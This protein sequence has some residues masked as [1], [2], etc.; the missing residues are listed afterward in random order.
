MA[1]EFD[2]IEQDAKVEE[3][4]PDEAYQLDRKAVSAILYAVDIE[5]QAKLIE[6]MDPLHPADIAD[7]LEQINA[8]D[9]SR[10]I[11]LY[12]REFDGDILSELDE[13]IRDEVIAVLTPQVLTQAVR[14][15]DSDDVVDL[16]EDMDDSQQEAILD[17][18]EDAD[19]LAVKQA[20]SYPEFSAGRLMQREVVMAPEHWTVGDA[21][22]HLR[23]SSEED[24]P[25]QFY[26]IVVVDPRLHPVGNV[27]LGKV[28][29]SR[30]DVPLLDIVEPTF[31]VIPATQ[32]ESDVAYAFNQYHLISAPVV[33]DEGRLIGLITIDDAMA[34]LDEEHEEDI[35]RL[36]GVG[37]GSLSDRVIETTKQRMPWLAVNLLTSIAASLVIAQFEVAIAQIVA[38][39]VLMPIVASMGGNAGTQS[40]TV[41]VRAIATKDLTGSN[42]WRVIRREVLVGLFNGLLFAVVMG[43]VGLVWF[44]SPALGYVIAAAMVVNMVVAGFAGTVIPVILDRVGVDP[45]LASGAFVTTVTD[46][47]GFFAFLGLAAAVLL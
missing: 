37:E 16:V 47:V 41:A 25:D 28:M 10:L 9:R 35:M 42:V 23:S 31:Q 33:D 22:D 15:L 46:V 34:V 39:A 2:T 6:L 45:A 8:Y 40:L 1:D 14:D 3:E 27:T 29:R 21:I 36:A 43:V 11:R 20:L 13:S 7:L 26:H 12:D 24:L 44:G 19:R 4:R 32:P 5:D 38:L 30:R 18:L 17:A